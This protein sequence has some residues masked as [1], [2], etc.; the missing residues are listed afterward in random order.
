[1]KYKNIQLYKWIQVI[2]FFSHRKILIMD[3]IMSS[4]SS[5]FVVRVPVPSNYVPKEEEEEEEEEYIDRREN[6]PL[7]FT[8]TVVKESGNGGQQSSGRGDE[9]G[10]STHIGTF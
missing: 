8:P 5:L 1:M 6:A 10:F 4:K 3:F 2:S 7:D 9:N